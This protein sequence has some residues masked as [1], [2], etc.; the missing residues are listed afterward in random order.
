MRMQFPSSGENSRELLLPE[1][2]SFTIIEAYEKNKDGENL[3]TRTGTPY[4]KL[5]CQEQE[6]KTAIYHVI[7]LDPEK[8]FK[9]MHLLKATG[10]TYA[11]GEDVDIFANMWIGKRFRGKIEVDDGRNKIK[12][13]E[14]IPSSAIESFLPEVDPLGASQPC[15]AEP[16]KE[17]PPRDPELDEE[18]PF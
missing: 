16:K 4:Q 11:D 6:S 8:P 14:P 15:P 1:W 13:V 10:I 12:F 5:V 17:E 3:V 2:Y 9:V 7:F 18:V